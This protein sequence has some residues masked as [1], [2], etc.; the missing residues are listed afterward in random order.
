M[1]VCRA[2]H[3][4]TQCQIEEQVELLLYSTLCL[5][6]THWGFTYIQWELDNK[7]VTICPWH[8]NNLLLLPILFYTFCCSGQRT[9]Q[10]L[11]QIAPNLLPWR[12]MFYPSPVHVRFEI[13]GRQRDNETGFS[14]NN[15]CFP[16]QYHY[17]SASFFGIKWVE[18]SWV[19]A[20]NLAKMTCNT[21][22]SHSCVS[23][24]LSSEM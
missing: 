24:D 7:A 18:I 20:I 19:I 10:W 21:G 6:V 8:E 1:L 2:N 13:Y 16:C 5:H 23:E 22:D 9:M 11:K 17:T 4:S 14:L 15:L 12:P 3:I